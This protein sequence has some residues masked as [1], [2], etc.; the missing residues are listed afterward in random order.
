MIARQDDL[1]V[2]ARAALKSGNYLNS[3]DLLAQAQQLG[4]NTRELQY[5]MVLALANAGSTRHALEQYRKLDLQADE[6]NE[7]WLALEG[8]LL[9]DLA[10]QSLPESRALFLSAAAAYLNSHERTGG[11][12]SAVNAATMFALG[13]DIKRSQ[14]LAGEVLTM[15]GAISPRDDLDHFYLL[16]TEAEA[17]LLRADLK[18]C[19]ECLR[20]ANRL[21]RD[22]LNARSRTRGQIKLLCQMLAI[23][24]KPY[25]LLSMPP[26]IYVDADLEVTE[27]AIDRELVN[28]LADASPLLFLGLMSPAQLVDAEHGIE[29]GARLFVVIP[30]ARGDEIVRWHHAYGGACSR[31]RAKRPAQAPP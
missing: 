18:R 1:I 24:G 25:R 7:D 8:R 9:K 21:L 11:Y 12:F 29:R 22:D 27:R 10:I 15:V 20:A 13:G 30:G 6:L 19:E 2:L 14:E 26:V 17:A 28:P 3:Y 4:N 23:K 16:A 31:Q 5:L